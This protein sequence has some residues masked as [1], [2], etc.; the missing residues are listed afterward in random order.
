MMDSSNNGV[1]MT[2]DNAKWRSYT[3]ADYTTLFEAVK[4]GAYTINDASDIEI[5]ELDLKKVAVTEITD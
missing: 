2:T 4:G 3:A 1:G 5:A